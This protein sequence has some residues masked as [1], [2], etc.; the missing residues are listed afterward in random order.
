LY[1]Q[2]R[3]RESRGAT[4]IAESQVDPALLVALQVL[5]AVSIFVAGFASVRI[6]AHRDRALARS[7][8]I[9]GQIRHEIE[10]DAPSADRE[11]R[12]L[13]RE[14]GR[15][16]EAWPSVIDATIINLILLG[17]VVLLETIAARQMAW[18]LDLHVS[19]WRVAFLSFAVIVVTQA[20]VVLA[21]ALDARQVR[22]ELLDKRVAT[23][24]G[25]IATLE[26]L[27]T[28]HDL[29]SATALAY[30]IFTQAPGTAWVAR[31]RARVQLEIG[32]R[33]HDESALQNAFVE[34]ARAMD[35]KAEQRRSPV[36]ELKLRAR[37]LE[38]LGAPEH[39]LADITEA[40]SW[41]ERDPELWLRSG[42]LNTRIASFEEGRRENEA[43]ARRYDEARRGYEQAT[44][45]D[46][47]SIEPLLAW[48]ELER[49]MKAPERAMALVE[50][51]LQMQ[52][53]NHAALAMQQSISRASRLPS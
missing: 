52:P 16:L 49:R 5:P 15:S 40:I 51:A 1:A 20:L 9:E 41:D 10:T 36:A 47:L 19:R 18:V 14:Y 27:L 4:E 21:G 45:L 46:V 17:M 3:L 26:F 25:R 22:A 44:K 13:S 35:L 2:R 34:L 48:A 53:G 12:E 7:D 33:Q 11:V 38:L 31:Q 29:D 50:Q 24:W 32:Q 37:T 30:R 23:L 8:G 43:A 28:K 42:Q 39:A 6:H